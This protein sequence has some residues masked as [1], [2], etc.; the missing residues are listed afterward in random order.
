[1]DSAV[2]VPSEGVD[3]LWAMK[4]ML[5]VS[6]DVQLTGG[7]EPAF[8]TMAYDVTVTGAEKVV[9]RAKGAD[10]WAELHDSAGK[11]VLI[12][13]PHKVE[14][15]NVPRPADSV[16][17]GEEYKITARR[18]GHVTGIADQGGDGDAAKLYDS[19][20][21]GVDVWAASYAD[22]Q[23]WSSMSSPSRLLYEVLAFEQ[24]GGYGFN[25]GLG[26]THGINRKDHGSDVDFVFEYGYWEMEE[27][28]LPSI[29]GR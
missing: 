9:A 22:G 11:D 10:D 23:T 27:S 20:E 3:V 21:E 7:A 19:G 29:R 16:E 15:M 14:I 1:M 28:A 2:V 12:A 13:K 25:G 6:H 24:V 5:R 8:A 17:R 4:D 18:Y 26:E